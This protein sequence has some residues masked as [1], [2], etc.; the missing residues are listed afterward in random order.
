LLGAEP[1]TP[2]G[3]GVADFEG[4]VAAVARRWKIPVAERSGGGCCA[5]QHVASGGHGIGFLGSMTLSLW[6]GDPEVL[7]QS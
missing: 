2:L 7:T 1:G 3:V 4:L 5:Q 6:S